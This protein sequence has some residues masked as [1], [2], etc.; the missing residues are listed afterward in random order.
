MFDFHL[1]NAA[2]RNLTPL[3]GIG[4]YKKRHRIFWKSL[5]M[6]WES[7]APTEEDVL[8]HAK[9]HWSLK[10]LRIHPGHVFLSSDHPSV[11]LTFNNNKPGLDM[12]LLPLTPSLIAVGYD[13]RVLEIVSDQVSLEDESTINSAQLANLDTCLFGSIAISSEQIQILKDHRVEK[14]PFQSEVRDD[15][16]QLNLK[17]LPTEHFFSFVKIR[18]PR[19]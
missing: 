4:A 2:H 6:G 1:R 19:F 3:E 14:S 12:V 8:H 13:K 18:P 17:R 5:F 15:I 9:R 11:W 7:S 16:W 10:I